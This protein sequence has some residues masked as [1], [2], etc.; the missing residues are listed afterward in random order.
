M[1]KRKLAVGRGLPMQMNPYLSFKG[2]CE[3]AFRFYAERLGGQLGPIFRYAGTPLSD[4]VPADWQDKVM[5]ASLTLGGQVLMGG[6]IAPD[7][8]E[9]PRGFS[10]SLHMKGI[11]DA[12]RIFQDLAEDGR[13]VVPL[14]KTFWAA[15]FGMLV[16]RFGIPWLINCDGS[17]PAGTASGSAPID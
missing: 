8:Y 15:R 9:E 11:A 5:H 6:D 2:Q 13:I 3:A 7:R 10:L 16:D 14:E 4:H 17:D 1:A 12:E